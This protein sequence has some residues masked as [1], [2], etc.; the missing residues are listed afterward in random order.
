MWKEGGQHD[1]NVVIEMTWDILMEK[2]KKKMMREE[3]KQPPPY[4]QLVG[5]L[6]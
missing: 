1:E 6:T 2:K 4:D 5:D 3:L